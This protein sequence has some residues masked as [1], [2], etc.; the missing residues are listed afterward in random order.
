MLPNARFPRKSAMAN[1]DYLMPFVLIYV[2]ICLGLLAALCLALMAFVAT[3][4]Y[5]LA[6]E[7]LRGGPGI[8]LMRENAWRMQRG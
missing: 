8:F 5:L 4:M 1:D 3:W 2:W 6:T 7:A